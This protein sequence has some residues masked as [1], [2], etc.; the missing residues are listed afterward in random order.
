MNETIVYLM[1]HADATNKNNYNIIKDGDNNQLVN[2]KFILSV[3]GEKFAEKL[4]KLDELKKIDAIYSSAYVRAMGTAKYFALENNTILNIDERLNE[5]KVGQLGDMEWKD[6]SRLQS[7]D[8]DFKLNGGESLN[9]TKKRMVEAMKNIIMYEAGNR[10]VVV[11]HACALTC[12]LS[13][14]CEVGK[15]Y[16]DDIILTYKETG[17]VDGSWVSPK[18]FKVT[19]DGM[20]VKNIEVIN[21]DE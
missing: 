18:I 19:F 12:L 6:F 9:Q 3:S 1:R 11:S 21:V 14:W 7:K 15:N 8:F 16:D 20:I 5:R 17:I 10:V 4:S 2:E 13:A